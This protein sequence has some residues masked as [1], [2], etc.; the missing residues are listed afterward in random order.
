MAQLLPP[1]RPKHK[2][3]IAIILAV[4]LHVLVAIVLY[5]T[6][7]HDTSTSDTL[8]SDTLPSIDER[9]LPASII[10]EGEQVSPHDMKIVT[11]NINEQKTDASASDSVDKQNAQLTADAK[12]STAKANNHSVKETAPLA[13]VNNTA[14]DIKPSGAKSSDQPEYKLEQTKETQ[15]LDEDID[16]DSEQLSKLIDEVKKRNQSQIQQHHLPKVSETP[17]ENAPRVQHDYPITPITSLPTQEGSA[18]DTQVAESSISK[19]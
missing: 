4:L 3:I 13:T 14:T 9:P 1:N 11:T 18:K 6:V 19:P 2:I 17:S 16:K 5:F 15:Q 8:S 12:S 10:T 7:F